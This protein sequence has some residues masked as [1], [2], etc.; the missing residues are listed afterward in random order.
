MTP[1]PIADWQVALDTMDAALAASLKALDRSE[2]R[3]ERAVAPSAG[4]G[5][6]PV[7][8]DRLEASLQAWEERLRG[9]DESVATVEQELTDRAAAAARW[10]ALYARWEELL[11]QRPHV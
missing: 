3:W 4:E 1:L 8:L 7:A 10:R 9:A 6:P 2:E 5:E 11:Q